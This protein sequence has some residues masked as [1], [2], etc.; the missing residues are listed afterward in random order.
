MFFRVK[1]NPPTTFNHFMPIVRPVTTVFPP[2]TN[3]PITPHL[4]LLCHPFPSL[5]HHYLTNS[6]PSFLSTLSHVQFLPLTI[7]PQSIPSPLLRHLS[8]SLLHHHLTRPISL[9]RHFFTR[10][11]ASPMPTSP[12]P[13]LLPASLLHPCPFLPHHYFTRPFP[14]PSTGHLPPSLPLQRCVLTHSHR[15][16]HDLPLKRAPFAAPLIMGRS[17]KHEEVRRDTPPPFNTVFGV[18]AVN[19]AFF[20][21]LPVNWRDR[22]TVSASAG[23]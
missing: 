9:P 8:P 5:P 7:S 17:Q 12:V 16:L 14:F 15:V 19:I 20:L 21:P 6:F 2:L 11:R 13:F 3:L 23:G 4:P 22:W 1:I 10:L 18:T